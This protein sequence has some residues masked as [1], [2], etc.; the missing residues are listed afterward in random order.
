MDRGYPSF[1]M[2]ARVCNRTNVLFRIRKNSFAQAKFLFAPH[3]EKKDIVLEI[4]APKHIREDLKKQNLP[5]KLKIRFVQV[6]LKNGT[7]EVLATNVLDGNILQTSDFMDL[8]GKRWGIETYYNVLKNRL[9][10]ENF[11]GLTA[12]SVKQDFYATIFL[13]NYEAMLVYDT[14]ID[15]GEK[16]KDNKYAEQVN[17]A[18]SFNAIKH[19]AFD[20]FYS[21]KSL[22][23]QIKELEKLFVMNTVPIRPDRDSPVRLDKEIQKSTIATNTINYIKRRKKNVGN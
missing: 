21:N 12:L 13:T 2:F 20:L 17:K 23:K 19:K 6:I 22:A 5:T 11:T 3:C 18:G 7:V 9:S 10:L 1:E 16:T 4:I 8:Y 15:L 14:N